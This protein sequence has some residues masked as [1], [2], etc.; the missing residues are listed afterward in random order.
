M[1]RPAA[2]ALRPALDTS[3][4]SLFHSSTHPFNV[5]YLE[6]LNKLLLNLGLNQTQW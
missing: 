3:L 6:Y 1:S 5:Y 2:Q 4:G